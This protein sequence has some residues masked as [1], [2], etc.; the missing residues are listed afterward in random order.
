MHAH[1][2]W[3]MGKEDVNV[4]WSWVQGR[5]LVRLLKRGPGVCL[6]VVKFSAAEECQMNNPE[7]QCTGQLSLCFI[8]QPLTWDERRAPRTSGSWPSPQGASGPHTLRTGRTASPLGAASCSTGGAFPVPANKP[9]D[10]QLGRRNFWPLGFG[11]GAKRGPMAAGG[12]GLGVLHSESPYKNY[13][14]R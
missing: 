10:E 11:Q 4:S 8:T 9:L 13:S 14:D 5:S 1:M 6:V 2:L 3:E 7:T 12:R